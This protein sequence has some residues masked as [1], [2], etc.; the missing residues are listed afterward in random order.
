VGRRGGPAGLGQ[1]RDYRLTSRRREPADARDAWLTLE[2]FFGD[3]RQSETLRNPA[4]GPETDDAPR[5]RGI[6]QSL[7]IWSRRDKP[8]PAGSNSLRTVI[9]KVVP[10]SKPALKPTL[11]AGFQCELA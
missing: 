10:N 4:R 1:R 6:R 2:V 9:F 8:L 11:R 5:S 7:A 3:H